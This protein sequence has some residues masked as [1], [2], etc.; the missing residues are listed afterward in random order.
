MLGGMKDEPKGG[1]G[2]ALPTNL[3]RGKETGLWYRA[4]VGNPCVDPGGKSGQQR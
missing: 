4:Q 2:E 1:R 3:A